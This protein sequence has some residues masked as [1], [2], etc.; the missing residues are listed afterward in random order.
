MRA[1]VAAQR[2]C[3]I[4]SEQ[5]RCSGDAADRPAGPRRPLADS[6][7]APRPP[8]YSRAMP[9]SATLCLALCLPR[10]CATLVLRD[11]LQW[12]P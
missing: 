7:R 8:P 10:C 5:V 4:G 12:S 1:M 11:A 9:A 2:Q 6:W 3:V